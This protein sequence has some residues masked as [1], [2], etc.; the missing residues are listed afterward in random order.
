[1]KRLTADLQQHRAARRYLLAACIVLI[2]LTIVSVYAA[3]RAE[4]EDVRSM[5]QATEA[6]VANRDLLAE[7]LIMQVDAETGVRGYVL[8][9]REEFLEPYEVARAQREALFAKIETGATPSAA[10]QLSELKRL[11]GAKFA[12]AELNI[13]DVRAGRA[14]QARARIAGGRGKAIMD[15]MRTEI[16][17]LDADERQRLASLTRQSADARGLLENS[18]SVMLAGLAVLLLLAALLVNRSLRLRSE[19]L[20]RA[21]LLARRQTAMFDGAVDGMLLLDGDG[22]IRRMNPSVSRMFGY[23][24]EDMVGQHNTALMADT[25]DRERSNGWLAS[26]GAAGEHGAGRRQEFTGRRADGSTFDTEVAISRVSGEGERR[27]V[28]AIRDISDRKRAEQMKTEFVSTV[29]HEL[30]T[31]LTSIG[32]SLGL[33]QAGAVGPLNE[34]AQRL[35]DIARSNCERLIRLIN[36]IL[37]IEKIESGRMEFDLRRMQVAPLVQ[38]T[39]ASMGGFA[40]QHGVTLSTQ[41]PPWPQCVMG[42]PDKLEQLLTNLVSNAVKHAPEGSEVEIFAGHDGGKVRVEVRDRGAGVPDEFRGRIFGKFAMADASDSRA[43][44]GTGLGL[45]IAREIARRH[46][47]DVG[48]EDRDGG[49]T[50]FHFDVPQVAADA[51]G[52]APE[53]D[54]SLPTILHVDDDQDTLSVV[55]S[56]FA[57]RAN[58]LAAHTLAGAREVLASTVI[59]AAILDVGLAYESGLELVP[60]LRAADNSPAIVAF[61]AVEDAPE[62]GTVDAVLIKSRASIDDLVARTLELLD[63]RAK[64]A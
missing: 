5:R 45:A 30:R 4:F 36:D 11:S 59:E 9:G 62:T 61:T 12:N 63:Y 32:G 10:R 57:G 42:D 19:A 37:D 15:R 43:K 44:G 64:A 38:R 60:D 8:T 56:V 13:A 51:P 34:K 41:L 49:G 46:G 21:N 40:E 33:L 39:V 25:F 53:R 22:V 23:G 24:E 16:A 55:A 29:S 2:P 26:V 3:M 31:P 17:A 52:G 6:T 20:E 47:G 14:E 18:V 50:V 27:Y 48:F 1:M 28:A 35:V 54:P 58:V 7:L